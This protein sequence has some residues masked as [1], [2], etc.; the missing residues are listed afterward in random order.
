MCLKV[1]IEDQVEDTKFTKKK[2]KHI[3]DIYLNNSL[4]KARNILSP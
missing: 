3:F 1:V 4:I 2:K